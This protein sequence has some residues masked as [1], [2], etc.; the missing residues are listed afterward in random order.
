MYI[1]YGLLNYMSTL[2]L[3][4]MLRFLY[5][6]NGQLHWLLPTTPPLSF[7]QVLYCLCQITQLSPWS[8]QR[9]THTKQPRGDLVNLKNI[10]CARHKVHTPAWKPNSCNCDPESLWSQW[11]FQIR[12]ANHKWYFKGLKQKACH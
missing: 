6:K 8:D 11:M 9:L 5:P 10:I 3:L 1:L 4:E 12:A 7:S 2:T